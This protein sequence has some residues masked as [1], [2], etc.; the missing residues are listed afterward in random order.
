MVKDLARVSEETG[1]STATLR[2]KYRRPLPKGQA[3]R[4][5]KLLPPASP[6][7]V[8]ALNS[9]TKPSPKSDGAAVSEPSKS[10]ASR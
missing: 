8:T 4:Y 5:F 9:L 1:T 6:S 10:V 7:N 3:A 2:K